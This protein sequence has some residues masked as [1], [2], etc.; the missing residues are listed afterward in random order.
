MGGGHDECPLVAVD[1]TGGEADPEMS[2]FK[3]RQ[4]NPELF[5]RQ[6]ST[7]VSHLRQGRSLDRF[8]TNSG[9]IP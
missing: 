8:A 4:T 1:S 2:P 5:A 7:R 9:R 3:I 6:H